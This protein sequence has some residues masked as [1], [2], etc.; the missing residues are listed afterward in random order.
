MTDQKNVLV[1]FDELD[2]DPLDSNESLV[3][4]PIL[5][6]AQRADLTAESHVQASAPYEPS[7]GAKMLSEQMEA[8]K[9]LDALLKSNHDKF[10]SSDKRII[11]QFQ[12]KASIRAKPGADKVYN[13]IIV[14]I[15]TPAGAVATQTAIQANVKQQFPSHSVPKD[16]T[17]PLPAWAVKK[18]EERIRGS[19]API[20]DIVLPKKTSLSQLHK[21]AAAAVERYKTGTQTFKPLIE[22]GESS[23]VI[24]GVPFKIGQNKVK[25]GVYEYVRLPVSTLLE[26][27]DSRR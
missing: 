1:E 15:L 2:L 12:V 27:L 20:C 19:A 23:V 8:Q 24:N 17:K 9:L 7:L 13:A 26:A 18:I 6:L 14:S 21:A 11:L 16:W 5:E 10:G 22:V 4:C 25:G 3:H